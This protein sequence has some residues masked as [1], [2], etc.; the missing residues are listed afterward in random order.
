M[1]RLVCKV[2][3]TPTEELALTNKVFLSPTYFEKLRNKSGALGNWLKVD[4]WVFTF[5]YDFQK[6]FSDSFCSQH[7]NVKDGMVAFTSAQRGMALL[8]LKDT[9]FLEAYIPKKPDI[10]LSRVILEVDFFFKWQT[11]SKRFLCSDTY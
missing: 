4:K 3:K 10:Y 5:E 6:I 11:S 9:M 2:T 8:S 7:E 1:T